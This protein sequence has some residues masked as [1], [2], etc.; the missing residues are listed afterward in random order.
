[1]A[2]A[3][4]FEDL[5]NWQQDREL[6]N[7][8]YEAFA[9]C[10]EYFFRD[11]IQRAATC[12][13]NNISQ[14]FERRKKNDFAHFFDLAKGSAGEVR[15]MINLSEDRKYVP[16]PYATGLR[17]RYEQLPLSIG[18]LASCAARNPLLP[19]APSHRL[20]ISL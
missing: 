14:G 6:A 2:L 16:G 7:A 4:R 18:A 12:V 9:E 17:T 5:K 8:V 10:R 20:R 13:M 19:H 3:G 1:M 11:Q 15:S